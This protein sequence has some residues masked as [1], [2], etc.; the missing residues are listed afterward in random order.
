ML[1]YLSATLAGDTSMTFTI[2][3]P[4]LA[5]VTV[6]TVELRDAPTAPGAVAAAAA[7]R[8]LLLPFYVPGYRRGFQL[9]RHE[10]RNL[11]HHLFIEPEKHQLLNLRMLGLD[12]R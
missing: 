4:E 6:G 5:A 11:Q 3:G 10:G 9:P 12:M 1:N 8:A 2:F 7:S